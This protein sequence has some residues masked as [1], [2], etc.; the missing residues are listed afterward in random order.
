MQGSSRG[1]QPNRYSQDPS[2]E[3]QDI[4][5]GGVH[6]GRV[7]QIQNAVVFRIRTYRNY[8]LNRLDYGSVIPPFA[9]VEVNPGAI[10]TIVQTLENDERLRIEDGLCQVNG[11]D[12]DSELNLSPFEEHT[13]YRG[14]SER[15]VEGNAW[16]ETARFEYA[17][18]NLEEYGSF[19]NYSSLEEFRTV[20]CEY[21]DELYDSIRNDGYRSNHSAEHDVPSVDIRNHKYR[22][23]HKL[24]PLIAI[25]RSG[26][27]HWVDGFHRVTIAKLLELDSIPVNVL[28]QHPESL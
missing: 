9:R 7:Q 21:I 26:D 1:R 23:F 8:V 15:F 27:A 20:R 2:H 28:C 12:W 25:D 10:S 14:L 11:S 16:E 4:T 22:Y 6:V 17:K 18:E 13:I 5:V 3:R 24:E 19:N